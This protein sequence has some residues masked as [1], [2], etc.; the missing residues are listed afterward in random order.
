MTEPLAWLAYDA[1][2]NEYV[3]PDHQDAERF[4]GDSDDAETIHPLVM[5]AE[6][7]GL[8]IELDLHRS[9]ITELELENTRAR[10]IEE[11]EKKTYHDTWQAAWKARGEYET[12]EIYR[13]R[14]DNMELRDMNARLQ[15]ENAELRARQE[16]T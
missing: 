11:F 10:R 9:R 6:V 1:H 2:G 5:Q 14:C 13:V 15:R 4:V 16:T 12:K 8:K 3:F 7:D